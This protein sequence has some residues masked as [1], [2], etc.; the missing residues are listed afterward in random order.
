MQNPPA[1]NSWIEDACSMG[2]LITDEDVGLELHVAMRFLIVVIVIMRPRMVSMLIKNIDMTFHAIESDRSY[3]R[4]VALNKR[5]GKSV[6][7]VACAWVDTSVRLA[8]CLMMIYQRSSI[9]AM[10]V[11]YAGL[12]G[13]RTSSIAINVDAAT[14]CS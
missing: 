3:V 6:S 10:D 2:V 12:A 14:L 9:I 1:Q 4:Y 5:F 7:I 11:A 13:G 8:S